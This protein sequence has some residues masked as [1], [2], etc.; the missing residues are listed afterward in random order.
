MVESVDDEQ[1]I[2]D[3]DEWQRQWKQQQCDR[4]GTIGSRTKPTNPV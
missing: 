2:T 3:D 4:Q 1:I